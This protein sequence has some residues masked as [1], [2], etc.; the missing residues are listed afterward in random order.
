MS[1]AA[2]LGPR[3]TTE[4]ELI[5]T[6]QATRDQVRNVEDCL[7]KVRLLVLAAARP[8]KPRRPTKPTRASQVRR[9]EEKARRSAAKQSR[10]RPETD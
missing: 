4:G 1:V 2:A 7:E 6:S 3:L 5:V 10:R 8:P 9:G